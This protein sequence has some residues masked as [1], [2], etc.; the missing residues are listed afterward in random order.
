M[1]HEHCLSSAERTQLA[2][3]ASS[4]TG[5]TLPAIFELHRKHQTLINMRNVILLSG[6]PEIVSNSEN[7][8]FIVLAIYT[9]AFLICVF[10]TRAIFSIPKF[11]KYQRAQTLALIKIAR[12][13]G[14]TEEEIKIIMEIVEPD[15]SKTSMENGGSLEKKD[16]MH[17]KN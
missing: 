12:A 5:E 3:T 7:N 4:L 9:G 14:V 13:N 1:F 11:L 16:R 8:F 15:E 2:L 10:I 6:F 17:L